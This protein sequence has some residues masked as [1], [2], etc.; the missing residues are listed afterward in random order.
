MVDG[1]DGGGHERRTR[2]ALGG[3]DSRHPHMPAVSGR[4]APCGR[5]R[6]PSSSDRSWCRNPIDAFLLARLEAEGLRP[7]TQPIA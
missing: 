2:E 3:E 4:F 5:R 1:V 7:A 6:F